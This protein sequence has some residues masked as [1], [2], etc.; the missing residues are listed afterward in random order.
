MIEQKIE[1]GLVADWK[2]SLIAHAI[3]HRALNRMPG[4]DYSLVHHSKTGDLLLVFTCGEEND[5]GDYAFAV[6]YRPT[7]LL[8]ST[9][10][11]TTPDD[12]RDAHPFEELCSAYVDGQVTYDEEQG[13][14]LDLHFGEA[15]AA[16]V[17]ELTRN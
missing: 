7:R 1:K 11:I 6:Y 17:E 16:A 10:S 9:F 3:D 4:I 12:L 15:S 5:D 13:A 2:R 8:M 14:C